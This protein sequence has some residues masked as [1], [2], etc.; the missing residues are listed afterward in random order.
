MKRKVYLEGELGEKYGKELTLNVNSFA[1]VF[2]LLEANYPDIRQYLL[3][4]HEK[5]IGF[6]CEIADKPLTTENELLLL[7]SEG[8]MYI[9]PQP[10]GSKSAG[11][12]ILAALAIAV[13]III[14]PAN[15]F[16]TTELVGVAS[17]TATFATTF[18]TAGLIAAGIAINLALTGIMQLMA[19][20]P[21]TDS[22]QD[23]SYLFQG[24]GQTII[25]GDPVPVLY[26]KLRVPGRPISFAIQNASQSFINISDY[27]TEAPETNT[28][29]DPQNPGAPDIDDGYNE[30]AYNDDKIDLPSNYSPQGGYSAKGARHVIIDGVS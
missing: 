2:R 21:A 29:V 26:G 27:S 25:E 15:I 14:N 6:M 23:E 17:T 28:P 16:Y 13:L 9:S 12:K 3:D 7:Y 5:D 11:A 19:P 30:P 1:E 20:D 18:S 4:C 22:L 24:S 10:M 8:D